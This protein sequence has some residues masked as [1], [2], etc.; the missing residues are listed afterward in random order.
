ML[1]ILDASALFQVE[2]VRLRKSVL[3]FIIHINRENW[4][5]ATTLAL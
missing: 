4:S 5:R 1:A 3:V 2:K